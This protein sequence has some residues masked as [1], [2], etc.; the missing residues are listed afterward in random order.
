MDTISLR[1][2]RVTDANS[3]WWGVPAVELMENAGRGVAAEADGMGDSFVIIC[4]PGNNG[5][6]GFTAA[7]HLKSK[8]KIIYFKHPKGKES[9]ENFEKAKNYW[10]VQVGEDNLQALK[11]ALDESEVVID[12]IFGTGIQGKMRE[13]YREAIKTINK[14]KKKVLSVDIPSGMDPDTGEV[15]DVCIKA[16]TTLA[17]HKVKEGVKKGKKGFAGKIKVLD[18]G[19]PPE[20]ETHIGPGDIRFRFPRREKTAHKGD[21]GKVLVVGGSENYIGAPYFAAMAAL[22]SGCDLVYVAAPRYAAEKIASMAPDVITI[23]LESRD[24]ITKKDLKALKKIDFDVACI[25]NGIG[26]DRESLAA[27]NEFVGK[28]GKPVVVD[29]DGLKA[30]TPAKLGNNVVLTPHGGE[31]KLLFGKTPSDDIEKRAEALKAAAKKTKATILLKGRIDLI[32]SGKKAKF[33]E[34]GAAYMSKGG[35]GDILAGICAGLMAQGVEP[36]DAAGMAAF[37]NGLAGEDAYA[38]NS[39]SMTASDVLASIGDVFGFL[40]G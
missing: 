16:T 39:I 7:R 11:T 22:R 23:P 19:I 27:V 28:L 17:L 34:T 33:N 30:V 26:A 29:G 4:G 2:M 14:G 1:D 13:P 35:T 5:G 38:H 21:A 12:A 15:S 36:F 40:L 25:G 31:F 32:A 18:I 6:D 20:A 10:P 9:K 24:H 37:V 3:E 8:P